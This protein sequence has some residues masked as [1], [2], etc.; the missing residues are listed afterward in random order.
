MLLVAL[1]ALA[2]AADP[3]DP[4][5]RAVPAAEAP[6]PDALPLPPS[7]LHRTGTT[8]LAVGGVTAVAAIPTGLGVAAVT[9]STM[10]RPAPAE[11]MGPTFL[12]VGVGVSMFTLGGTVA[13]VGGAAVLADALRHDH[14]VALVVT[15]R[16]VAL[17]GRF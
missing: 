13:A 2:F 12:G 10:C 4:G 1:S 11:C 17:A 8:L 16:S 5:S 7:K 14:D 15:P 9:T 3:V 6:G